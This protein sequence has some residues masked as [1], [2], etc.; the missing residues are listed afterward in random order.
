MQLTT[1]AVAL[2]G[3]GMRER[4][5]SRHINTAV[6]AKAQ[7]EARQGKLPVVTVV[8]GRRD[9]REEDVKPGGNITYL[10]DPTYMAV[11]WLF[12]YLEAISPVDKHKHRDERVFR[13]SF[14]LISGSK[15][16][17]RLELPTLP[18]GSAITIVNQRFGYSRL[19]EHG[20]SMQAPS[21]VMAVAAKAAQAVFRRAV[22]IEYTWAVMEV[23]VTDDPKR[24]P[25][26]AGER[27][28]VIHVQALQS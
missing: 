8:D 7:V 10:F 27:Y 5:R 25:I 26:K 28:P 9:R 24:D 22:R 13:D 14:V 1:A 21:G 2:W 12:K 6:A 16:V 4:L 3:A 11:E 18:F 19:L 17:W 15:E 23:D 20:F